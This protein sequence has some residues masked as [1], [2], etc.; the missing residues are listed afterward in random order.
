MNSCLRRSHVLTLLL[1]DEK[2]DRV[3][4]QTN[5]KY[6]V[7]HKD[8]SIHAELACQIS[9]IAMNIGARSSSSSSSPAMGFDFGPYPW[10][11]GFIVG[12][13]AVIVSESLPISL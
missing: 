12:A 3:H 6:D 5:E 11:L 1:R 13:P 8:K 4:D 7:E 9:A 10:H 2:P